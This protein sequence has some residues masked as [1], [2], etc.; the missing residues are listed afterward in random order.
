MGRALRAHGFR[1]F[2]SNDSAIDWFIGACSRADVEDAPG[3]AQAAMHPGRDPRVRATDIGVT[4]SV[5]GVI[6]VTGLIFSGKDL[7]RLSLHNSTNG[8]KRSGDIP[9]QGKR[10]GTTLKL[11]VDQA[12]GWPVWRG[13]RDSHRHFP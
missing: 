7:R 4:T 13:A 8:L 2:D 9:Y 11:F 3:I 12:R 6:D 10:R 1:G 5:P